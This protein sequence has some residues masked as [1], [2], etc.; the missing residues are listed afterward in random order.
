MSSEQTDLLQV[1]I[2]G[3]EVLIRSSEIREVVRPLPLTRVPMGPDHILGLA[4]IHGQIVSV[5]DVVKVSSLSA[6]SSDGSSSKARFLVL[7]HPVMHVAV[8]VDEVKRLRKVETRLL[9][10]TKSSSDTV[11]DI[12]IDGS[13]FALLDT[14]KLFH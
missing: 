5:I 12:D 8:W 9:K 3:R 13:R 14:G 10:P 1:V 2:G 4:N 6:I 11:H 7:R